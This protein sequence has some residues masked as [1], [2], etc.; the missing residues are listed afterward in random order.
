MRVVL[1]ALA[2][3]GSLQM[4]IGSAMAEVTVERSERGAVVKIDGKLFTEYLTKAGRSPSLWP[5]IGPTGKEM[6]RRWPT[7][8]A[9]DGNRE[10][11]DH[12]HHQSLWFTQDKMNG[13]DYWQANVN[14]DVEL[15]NEA[16][17]RARVD[18]R[19]LVELKSGD[20]A[21]VVT[22]NDWMNGDKRIC[23]DERTLEFGTGPDGARWID[24]TITLKPVD[25][26]LK[27]GDT[28]EG[29]FAMRV[30]DTMRVEAKAGGRIVNNE[31]LVN[32][33]AWGLPAK[34]VDYTGFV[35]PEDAKVGDEQEVVGICIMSHPKSFRP[36]PRW[37]ARTY[38]LFGANP[39]GQHEFPK[40]ELADQGPVTIK[41]GDAL[42]L[43]Y[44]VLLHPGRT[45]AKQLNEAFD[46]FARN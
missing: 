4:L 19:E 17:K 5:V 16:A 34:W 13:V 42:T 28:K 8:P 43:R 14:D 38:G 45:D 29:A 24:F 41:K 10:T 2:I 31:G 1:V 6:T 35:T 7:G 22:R 18:H 32:D 21:R 33:A 30:A 39:F 11:N 37:H 27:I 40:P 15:K 23:E 25:D 46:E 44:R 26:D 12:P 20:T 36:V 3:G 9:R